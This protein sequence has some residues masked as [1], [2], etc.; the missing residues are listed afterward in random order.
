VPDGFALSSKYS[1]VIAFDT[2]NTTGTLRYSLGKAQS[3]W[4]F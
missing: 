1:Y 2:K 4:I 3:S